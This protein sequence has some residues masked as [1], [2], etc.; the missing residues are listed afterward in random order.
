MKFSLDS[1]P[2]KSHVSIWDKTD[3]DEKIKRHLLLRSISAGIMI[4]VGCAIFL[5]LKEK[6]TILAAVFF[7]IGLL[8]I[9]QTKM[10]LFTGVCGYLVDPNKWKEY[11]GS[12]PVEIALI[13]FG[14]LWGCFLAGALLRVTNGP[15]KFEQVAKT[16]WLS[17][18]Q[19]DSISLFILGIFCGLLMFIAVDI[20]KNEQFNQ[21]LRCLMV[22]FCVSVFILCGFEHCIA[23]MGYFVLSGVRDLQSVIALLIIT[24]GNLI[25]GISG[26]CITRD[27][28]DD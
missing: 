19:T 3:I 20:W 25:G 9:C 28:G 16:L 18:L 17:K 5:A 7:S 22:V 8:S 26:F 23:D 1:H 2:C 10:K 12:Y 27:H 21:T 13:W 11:P 4:T 24:F 15:V 14:N 6:N